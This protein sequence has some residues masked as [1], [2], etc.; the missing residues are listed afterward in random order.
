MKR[1]VLFLEWTLGLYRTDGE[2]KGN[3]AVN[4]LGEMN[5]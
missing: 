5:P 4:S 2:K 3:Y 1:C